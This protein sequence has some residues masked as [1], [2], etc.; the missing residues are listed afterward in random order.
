MANNGPKMID[1]NLFIQAGIDPKTGL[2]IK[3]GNPGMVLKDAIKRVIK[4]TDEQNAVNRYVW[5]NLPSGLL[6]VDIER[7]LYYRGQLAMFYM[8]QNN[9]FY[10][11]P[12]AAA[13]PKGESGIDIYGR[14]TGITPL[15][16]QGT[17]EDG[18]V[19]DRA[20]IQGLIKRPVYSFEDV[21]MGEIDPYEC[22]VLLSDMTKGISQ[23]NISREN[24]NDAIIDAEAEAFPLARTAL[25]ANSG[26]KG[27]RV[28]DENQYANVKAASQSI[29]HAALTGDPWVP[30]VGNVEFQDFTSNGSALKSEEFLTYMQSLDNFRLSLLGLQTG[31]LFQK[32]EHMLQDEYDQNAATASLVY[33]DGL[34][35][36]QQFA[37][38]CNMIWGT[39]I[40]VDEP[41]MV[42]GMDKDMD[43]DMN[44]DSQ[45]HQ[46]MRGDEGGDNGYDGYGNE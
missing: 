5:Y 10:C 4:I 27:M 13:S 21:M 32:K 3:M 34:A 1:P 2:P 35:T 14:F 12:Y 28:N 42:S 31:G 37:D 9:K 16:F 20:F 11:L 7:M 46:A 24:L 30:F 45:G 22:C 38:M 19:K 8:S 26:I 17:W 18:K 40:Y 23:T 43:G 41:E 39:S 29:T 15:T 6:G 25:I 44:D 36:R 33:Q